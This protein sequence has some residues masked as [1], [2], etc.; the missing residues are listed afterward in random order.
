MTAERQVVRHLIELVDARTVCDLKPAM[1]ALD[2]GDADRVRDLLAHHGHHGLID[3]RPDTVLDAVL[4]AALVVLAWLAVGDPSDFGYAMEMEACCRF[5]ELAGL[6]DGDLLIGLIND[7][8]RADEA[9]A[10]ADAVDSGS[11]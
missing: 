5:L 3:I 8:L 11:K 6:A 1:A 7:G 10:L 9:L 2:S 4:D